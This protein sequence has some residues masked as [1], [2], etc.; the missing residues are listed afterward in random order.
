MISAIKAPAA[1]QSLPA[2]TTHLAGR[3]IGLVLVSVVPALFWIA[4]LMAACRIFGAQYSAPALAAAAVSIALFLA[5][6]CAP[7]MASD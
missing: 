1:L 2:S 6:V 7:I 5:A 3:T 4:V